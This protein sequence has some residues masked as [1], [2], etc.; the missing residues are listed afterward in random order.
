MTVR[1]EERNTRRKT[2]PISTLTAMYLTRPG[3]GS[4]TGLRG[5]KPANDYLTG[6]IDVRLKKK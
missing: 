2:S 4:T 1:V 5:Q 6:M 3:P